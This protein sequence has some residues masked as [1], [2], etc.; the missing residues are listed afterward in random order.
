[1][2]R[3]ARVNS[4]AVAHTALSAFLLA[5]SS[6]FTFATTAAQRSESDDAPYVDLLRWQGLAEVSGRSQIGVDH[7]RLFATVRWAIGAPRDASRYRIRVA[8][9]DGTAPSTYALAP[10]EVPGTSLRRL[11][12]WVP[13]ASVRNRRA[14]AVR[15]AVSVIDA[16]TG[17][18]VS[19]EALLATADDFPRDGPTDNPPPD[20]YGWGIPLAAHDGSAAPVGRFPVDLAL[21][22]DLNIGPQGLQFVRVC[23][24]REQPGFFIA[25]AEARIDQI[26]ALVKG[27]NPNLQIGEF[28]FSPD[29]PAFGVSAAQAESY[30]TA[31]SQSEGL[32]IS[33]RLPSRAEWLRMAKAGKSTRFWWGDDPNDTAARAG[34]NFKGAERPVEGTQREDE[35]DIIRPTPGGGVSQAGFKPNPWRLWHTFGNVSEWV[36]QGPDQYMMMGGDFRT[37]RDSANFRADDLELPVKAGEPHQQ[38]FVGV[39]VLADIGAVSGKAAI[40]SVL[41]KHSTAKNPLTSVSAEYDPETATATLTGSIADAADRARVDELLRPLWFLASLSNN[42]AVQGGVLAADQVAALGAPPPR[43]RVRVRNVPSGR[44]Y[45]I[46]VTVKWGY[47]LPVAG[48]E[49]WINVFRRGDGARISAAQL[50]ARKVGLASEI[51]VPIESA[52]MAGSGLAITEPV[53][54]ALSLGKEPLRTANDSEIVS[55]VADL[56]WAIDTKLSEREP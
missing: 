28:V 21:G 41:R 35:L 5:V 3:P 38:P 40:E 16:S 22:A 52:K 1:M 14:S 42:I 18:P 49:Y 55:N 47:Q 36:T 54:I 7:F 26:K 24:S 29:S 6:Q 12:V 15:V 27:Y 51:E 33:Y 10:R 20:R 11:T 17:Q 48:S 46:P 30:V 4:K 43:S 19:R 53:R 9:T 37:E 45:L 39:R 50:T 23:R 8:P 13:A 32:G 34:A 31:L 56:R 44:V 2:T 25:V